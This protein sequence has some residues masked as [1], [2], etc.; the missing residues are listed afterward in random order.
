[1]QQK[2]DLLP[3]RG[4]RGIRSQRVKTFIHDRSTQC[5]WCS[6]TPRRP[7]RQVIHRSLHTIQIHPLAVTPIPDQRLLRFPRQSRTPSS[8]L[9]TPHLWPG[10][11]VGAM[12]IGIGS[13][14]SPP[15]PPILTGFHKPRLPSGKVSLWGRRVPGSK[16]D[17]TEDPP[18]MRPVAR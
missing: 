8:C 10:S 4:N 17:S 13:K 6:G 15:D 2:I 1:M 12:N 14:F 7:F 16:P 11:A 9:L 3:T 18:C 5:K